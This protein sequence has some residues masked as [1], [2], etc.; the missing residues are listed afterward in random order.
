MKLIIN[1]AVLNETKYI[2]EMTELLK[3]RSMRKRRTREYEYKRSREVVLLSTCLKSFVFS[4][5]S[6]LTLMILTIISSNLF[7]ESTSRFCH[8]QLVAMIDVKKDFELKD[9]NYY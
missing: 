8:R 9:L 5:L 2:I 4:I 6:D 3:R 7:D 1:R